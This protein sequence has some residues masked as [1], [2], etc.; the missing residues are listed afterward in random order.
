LIGGTERCHDLSCSLGVDAAV[1]T[2]SW[3]RGGVDEP[4]FRWSQGST[5]RRGSIVASGRNLAT[6]LFS[7]AT[8]PDRAV[9]SS[10]GP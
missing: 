2:S 3:G 7:F 10:A 6:P 8:S 1:T 4:T 5:N 9:A